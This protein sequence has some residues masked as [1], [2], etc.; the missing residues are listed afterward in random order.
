MNMLKNL[1]V[2]AKLGVLLT[3]LS[4]LL[5]V[6]GSLGLYGMNDVVTSLRSVYNDR[7][8]PLERLAKIRALLLLNRVAITAA[9]TSEDEAFIREE[10]AQVESN[11]KAID[12]E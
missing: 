5:L 7:T 1:S 11:L 2:K 4:T 10:I 8:I 12:E 3:L 6:I 9:V